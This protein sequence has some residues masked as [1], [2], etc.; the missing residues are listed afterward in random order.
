MNRE[1]FENSLI[2]NDIAEYYLSKTKEELEAELGPEISRMVGFNQKNSHHCYDLWEHTLRTVESINPE[3]LTEEQFKQLR[4][5][6]FFHDIGKPDVAR[7]NERTGQQVFYGHAAHSVD[8][9]RPILERLGY[10]EQEISKLSFLIGHHDDFI[11]YKSK[12]AP[13]MVN[14][15][16]IR[17]INPTSVAEKIIENRYDFEAMGYNKDQIRA[18]CYTLAHGDKPVFRS[19]EGSFV[20]DVNMDEVQSKIESGEYNSSFDPSLEDYQM[21]LRLCKADANAQ[22][23]IAM[24]GG[25][26]VG[27]KKEKLENMVN[28]E[29]SLPE[30]YKSL[31]EKGENEFLNSIISL[32][33][34]RE[35][36]KTQNTQAAQ[37]AKEYERQSPN[38]GISIDDN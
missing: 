11:S 21:L 29:N 5:S 3:G 23:E 10:S 14:H 6:A 17:G 15:E 22:S 34:S 27:S 2:R 36:L 19:K 24:Q 18:I 26:Q 38:K 35:E 25:R 32:A 12:L 31:S 16:F 37:L 28:I 8:V 13:F 4:V 33:K 7:F 9:A 30:A 1:E 20:I